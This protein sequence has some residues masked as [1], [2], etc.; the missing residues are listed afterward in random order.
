MDRLIPAFVGMAAV[1]MLAYR[2]LGTAR[3]SAANS[4]NVSA[5]AG[6]DAVTQP[7]GQA[8]ALVAG[9]LFLVAVL[10]AL[11]SIIFLTR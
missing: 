4:T 8:F 1:L 9:N 5:L 2:G 11:A 6:V 10:A 7:L 3:E